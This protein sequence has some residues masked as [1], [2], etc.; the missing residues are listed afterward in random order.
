MPKLGKFGKSLGG[1]G[2]MPNLKD[3]TIAVDDADLKQK[4]KE[5]LNGKAKIRND[6]GGIIHV[7]V[8]KVSQDTGNLVE[9]IKSTVKAV[10]KLKPSDSKGKYLKR[11]YL[12]TTMG[13]AIKIESTEFE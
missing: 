10:V 11:I 2:L 3:E 6:K 5:F 7:A 1:M 9:N 12:S 8:G 4:I 13:P